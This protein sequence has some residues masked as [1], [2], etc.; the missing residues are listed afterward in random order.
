MRPA[1]LH[2]RLTLP[3]FQTLTTQL[4]FAQDPHLHSDPADLDARGL[5]RPYFACRFGFVLAS[6]G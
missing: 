6:A 3:G 5:L 2:V 1:H 4:F